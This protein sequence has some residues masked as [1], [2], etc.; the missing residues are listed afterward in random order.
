MCCTHCRI[1][2]ALHCLLFCTVYFLYKVY[3]MWLPALCTLIVFWT[4]RLCFHAVGNEAK[5]SRAAGG[6]SLCAFP[7]SSATGSIAPL[8][9][10]FRIT[11]ICCLHSRVTIELHHGAIQCC[12]IPAVPRSRHTH[13]NTYFLISVFYVLPLRCC[14]HRFHIIVSSLYENSP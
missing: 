3:V 8:F 2:T 14:H 11:A 9:Q 13:G 12:R 4:V 1:C 7:Y 6:K 10:M 5:G